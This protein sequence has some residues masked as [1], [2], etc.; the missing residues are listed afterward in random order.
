MARVHYCTR[1]CQTTTACFCSS[2]IRRR[3][4]RITSRSQISRLHSSGWLSSTILIRQALGSIA[5]R[6]SQS[7]IQHPHCHALICYSY[8]CCQ[9]RSLFLTRQKRSLPWRQQPMIHHLSGPS[10]C[11]V[12]LRFLTACGVFKNIL[13]DG[14]L[15]WSPADGNRGNSF[16][17]KKLPKRHVFLVLMVQRRNSW[18]SVCAFGR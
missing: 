6:L 18:P 2:S 10:L 14:N 4:H 5:L 13:R 16:I 7:Q 9:H 1:A 12:S 8:L 3:A 15:W 11:E 17:G